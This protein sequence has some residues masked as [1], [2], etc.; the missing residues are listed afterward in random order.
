MRKC[1]KGGVGIRRVFDASQIRGFVLKAFREKVFTKLQEMS[2]RS[3]LFPRNLPNSPFGRVRQGM[4]SIRSRL[5]QGKDFLE[6]LERMS[7]DQVEETMK[8]L[9]LRTFVVD[10]QIDDSAGDVDRSVAS[11]RVLPKTR[12]KILNHIASERLS[13]LSVEGKKLLLSNLIPMLP[14]DQKIIVK[15]LQS[16]NGLDLLYLKEHIDT[17]YAGFGHP[18]IVS[19]VR[20]I[21]T[22][23]RPSLLAHIRK[24]TVQEHEAIHLK[25]VSDLDDTLWAALN[26]HKVRK[27]TVYKQAVDFLKL[28]ASVTFL[29]ARPRAAGALTKRHLSRCGINARAVSFLW[30]RIGKM[31]SHLSMADQKYRNFVGYHS[32]FPDDCIIWVVVGDSGQGDVELCRRIRQM[33][34]ERAQ[35]PPMLLI[36]DVHDL[37]SRPKTSEEERERLFRGGIVVFDTYEEAIRHCK[38]I[39]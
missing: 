28:G 22:K 13:Q 33:F 31:F 26:D 8:A 23:L 37:K 10:A 39:K 5:I 38:G 6:R 36:H 19:L 12:R 17:C 14:E 24:N 34:A 30:G 16:S 1:S 29:S 25:I 27:G 15:V 11:L 7:S 4:I 21:S 20:S 18:S 32:L 3:F 35:R 2:E 9:H